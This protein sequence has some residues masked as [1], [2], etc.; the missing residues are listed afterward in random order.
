M[1]QGFARWLFCVVYRAAF[2][3]DMDLDLA[4][5]DWSE[6]DGLPDSFIEDNERKEI[7]NKVLKDSL[8]EV[9]YQML[10]MRYF[11]DMKEKDIADAMSCPLGTVKS[12]I[13]NAKK[14]FKT[15]LEKY[16]SDNKI[17]LSAAAGT[18]PFLTRFFTSQ[19]NLANMSASVATAAGAGA[20]SIVS[21]A[22]SATE[23][24]SAGSSAAASGTASTA[25]SSPS[26]AAKVGFLSTVGGKVVAGSI[27]LLGIGGLGFAGYKIIVKLSAPKPFEINKYVDYSVNGYDSEG[28]LSYT[29]DYDS[30]IKDN[31]GLEGVSADELQKIIGGNWDR[32]ESLS[33]GDNIVFTWVEGA[34]IDAFEKD[35][36]VDFVHS[37]IKYQVTG[38]EELKK[39][40]L[41]DY[42]EVSFDGSDGNGNVVVTVSDDIPVKD[43]VFEA[44]QPDA[45][46]NDQSV[47]ITARGKDRDIKDILAEAGYAYEEN[48]AEQSFVVEGLKE[49]WKAEKEASKA[50][51]K[52]AKQ[53]EKEAKKADKEAWKADKEARKAERKEAKQAEKEARKEHKGKG[54]HE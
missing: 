5:E 49:A 47:V 21:A 46:S 50:E 52:E 26:T 20:S 40:N 22:S 18:T 53:A 2:S 54:H 15:A 35:K 14:R 13:S 44:S 17:V 6:V 39:I 38:L 32:T 24:A 12:G 27:L 10:F 48:E 8:S 3:D 36:K 29:I 43:I 34:D 37:D 42:V 4:S 16:I 11:N 41:F 30:M 45:L 9:Q 25:A 7:I 28:K 23:A 31:K 33:N 1:R 19:I 51:R